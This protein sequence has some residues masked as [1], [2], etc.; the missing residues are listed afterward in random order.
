MPHSK[1][2]I[3]EQMTPLPH[4]I[5]DQQTVARAAERMEA[6]GVHHLPVTRDEGLVGVLSSQDVELLRAVDPDAPSRIPVAEAMRT[7]I[8]AVDPEK[9][10]DGAV[11]AMA[12]GTTDCCV[13]ATEGRVLGILTT[14]DALH[15]LADLLSARVGLADHGLA[16]SEVRERIVHEHESLRTMMERIE[17]LAASV[18]DGDA[19]ADAALRTETRE[20]YQTLLRH[21]ELENAILAPALRETDAF[22]P[23]RADG[24]L[25]EHERQHGLLHS[26]L[27]SL[28]EHPAKELARTVASFIEDLR[29]DME[30]EEKALL[31]PELLKDDPITTNSFTG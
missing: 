12:K 31:D 7:D 19:R 28:D 29:R 9:P 27:A 24:L 2:T 16:P 3:R 25:R 17:T 8:C 4:T 6:L 14:T 22:G 5:D 20:L 13:V 21:I 18:I 26:A 30:H 15:L 10:L 23:A 1:R 11:R